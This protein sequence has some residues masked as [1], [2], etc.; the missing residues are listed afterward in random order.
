MLQCH[1]SFK[2]RLK[3]WYSVSFFY[4]DGGFRVVDSS[5]I[6]SHKGKRGVIGNPYFGNFFKLHIIQ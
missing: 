4:H 2:G 6:L 5:F 3:R 1:W